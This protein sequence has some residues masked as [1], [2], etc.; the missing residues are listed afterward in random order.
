MFTTIYFLLP[1]ISHHLINLKKKNEK[2]HATEDA[3]D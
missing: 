3:I 2:M 1:E